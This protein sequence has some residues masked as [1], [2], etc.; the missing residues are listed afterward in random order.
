MNLRI[1]MIIN[2]VVAAVFGLAFLLVPD[3]VSTQYGIE[4]SAEL[5]Y[6]ARV[7]GAA[8]ISF[9]VLTWWARNANDSTARRAIVLAFLIGNSAGFVVALMG[10]LDEIPNS[11]G[12]ST[13]VIYLLFALGYGYFQFVKPKPKEVPHTA[14]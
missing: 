6:L 13:V 5:E 7:L 4:A 3:Q 11:L 9:A 12:W 14:S 1:L 8:F 2:A 10:Q